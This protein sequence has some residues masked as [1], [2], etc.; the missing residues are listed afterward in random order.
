MVD[1]S[2]NTKRFRLLVMAGVCGVVALSTVMPLRNG[3]AQT[4]QRPRRLPATGSHPSSAL[5]HLPAP[6]VTRLPGSGSRSTSRPMVSSGT[7]IV[8]KQPRQASS[9]SRPMSVP[10]LAVSDV[11]GVPFPRTPRE[12]GS[13]LKTDP[14]EQS[15]QARALAAQEGLWTQPSTIDPLASQFLLPPDSGPVRHNAMVDADGAAQTADHRSVVRV[16]TP[17]PFNQGNGFNQPSK[18][19]ARVVRVASRSLTGHLH[20]AQLE[21]IASDA[22]QTASQSLR[23]RSLYTARKSAYE[24]LH[25]VV[26]ARDVDSDS[27]RHSKRLTTA[28]DAIREAKDFCGKFGLVNNEAVQRMVDSHA[29]SV[30]KGSDLSKVAAIKAVEAYLTIAKNNLVAAS[31]SSI[32]ASES[33]R[34]LGRIQGS[35]SGDDSIYNKAVALT[36]L[37]AAVEAR[38]SNAVAH[39]DLGQ[40]LLSQGL[41]EQAASSLRQSIRLMPTRSSIQH[42]MVA[43]QQAGDARS[44][45]LCQ[46]TLQSDRLPSDFP[47][48]RLTP[49]QFAMTSRKQATTPPARVAAKPMATSHE[50][51]GFESS[52]SKGEPRKNW[53]QFWRR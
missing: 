44:V 35:L 40:T 47:I 11:S 39:R 8:A 23:K 36:W 17:G 32:E 20:S 48:V 26:A 51:S 9:Q 34:L 16:G 50:S 6:V 24:A 18:P 41:P 33:L 7:S 38:P 19:K 46:A 27:N 43:S 52:S 30:L 45:Q 13:E 4:P 10:R 1:R 21:T 12:F 28:L 22:L 29:T 37:Q 25:S 5:P 42:L 2:T 3:W 15:S 53:Y 14:M 49:E 31:G